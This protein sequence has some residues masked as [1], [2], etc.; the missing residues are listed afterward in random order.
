MLGARIALL[1]RQQ[2]MSQAELAEAL[3][4]SPSAVGMYEQGRREPA[5]EVLVAMA[6][7]F[8]VTVDYLLTGSPR[9]DSDEETLT[10]LMGGR[11][12][13][14]D[15]RLGNRAGRSF[16]RQELATLLAALLQDA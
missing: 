10:Q 6:Q 16:S 15:K 5:A 1:R 12:A 8:G 13:A 9:N 2:S 3:R 7:I 11:L 14:A 4:I